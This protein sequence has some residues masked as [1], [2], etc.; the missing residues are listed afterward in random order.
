MDN[1]T[2]SSQGLPGD[3]G[4]KA[5]AAVGFL[6]SG[7][8]ARSFAEWSAL[9][10]DYISQTEKGLET[11]ESR[12]DR[13]KKPLPAERIDALRGLIP[14]L[15]AQ[16]S[17]IEQA[18]ELINQP[19]AWQEQNLAQAKDF[20]ET[21]LPKGHTLVKRLRE[22]REIEIAIKR[23]EDLL[24]TDDPAD[25]TPCLAAWEQLFAVHQQKSQSPRPSPAL[26]RSRELLFASWPLSVQPIMLGANALLGRSSWD[27]EQRTQAQELESMIEI[28][29]GRLAKLTDAT[30]RIFEST[31]LIRE[32]LR[33]R[34]NER[35]LPMVSDNSKKTAHGN[36]TGDNQPPAPP[37]ADPPPALPVTPAGG[38]PSDEHNAMAHYTNTA[39]GTV[40]DLERVAGLAKPFLDGSR[41]PK[42][43]IE[44]NFI[45]RV[46][47]FIAEIVDPLIKLAR[48]PGGITGDELRRALSHQDVFL[49][50][51]EQ[52]RG[53]AAAN[54]V[55]ERLN[56]ESLQSAV[57]ALN[58]VDE[59]W[60][61]HEHFSLAQTLLEHPRLQ[62]TPAQQDL[63]E[64][65]ALEKKILNA[66][67]RA[68]ELLGKQSWTADEVNQVK[69]LL[70]SGLLK[71]NGTIGSLQQRLTPPPS[72][73]AAP[74][75]PKPK[76][77]DTVIFSKD[78]KPIDPW[79]K[80]SWAKYSAM[81]AAALLIIVGM[82]LITKP[83]VQRWRRSHANQ[84]ALAAAQPTPMPATPPAP[85]PVDE[86]APAE[87]PAQN[88]VP[89]AEVP[90]PAPTVAPTN[91][92][93][94][95]APANPPADEPAPVVVNSPAERALTRADFGGHPIN[96]VPDDAQPRGSW[97]G[98]HLRCTT[99]PITN[100]NGFTDYRTC[101]YVP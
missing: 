86:P 95:P 58:G 82:A 25:G 46:E 34:L 31:T 80:Q 9:C 36:P 85:P 23:M 52:F 17:V 2:F 33:D 8:A 64:R 56:E 5:Q 21:H 88:A 45:E 26:A 90:A 12:P 100:S 65:L 81:A 10:Q 79:W 75:P 70:A 62:G 49:C 67:N 18:F 41:Q 6:N 68:G 76:P 43:E 97:I 30:T 61:V 91:E 39:F 89:V 96:R 3:V 35:S 20:S 44:K 98:Q 87:P 74:P 42:N 19:E 28:A 50:A 71:N 14:L 54:Q 83:I 63:E 13:T 57:V 1:Y 22:R 69:N 4:P 94:A 11:L 15:Q 77:T 66:K 37:Q 47:R 40:K 93:P 59:G 78:A 24:S 53:T 92:V 72:K 101:R 29:E 38:P 55:A 73:T 60:W 16:A 32:R 99:P 84:A 48:T 27:D 7:G 51:V